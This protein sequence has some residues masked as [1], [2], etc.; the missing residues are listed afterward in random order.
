MDERLAAA[1]VREYTSTALA[2]NRGLS[3]RLAKLEFA[4]LRPT[5]S[6]IAAV[7]VLCTRADDSL[8]RYRE[9]LQE[10]LAAL[11]TALGGAGVGAIPA[12]DA[13]PA[14]ACGLGR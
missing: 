12:P 6:T 14:T 7:N 10:D 4:D 1:V 2:G 5:E 11:N 9:F 3:S 8:D 13:P